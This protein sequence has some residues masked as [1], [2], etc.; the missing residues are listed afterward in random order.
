M[1]AVLG[2]FNVITDTANFSAARH[3]LEA[4]VNSGRDLRKEIDGRGQVE[5]QEAS[6]R[7][8]QS[9]SLYMT[10]PRVSV[11]APSHPAERYV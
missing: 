6:E 10:Q 5:K 3:V 2:G 11:M 4:V 1:Y 8:Y 7:A 9:S